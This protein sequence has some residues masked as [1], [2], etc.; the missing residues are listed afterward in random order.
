MEPRSGK[1]LQ[2]VQSQWVV[3][4]ALVLVEVEVAIEPAP[5]V[6]VAV[7]VAAGIAWGSGV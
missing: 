2:P 4:P 6:A 3:A 1:M 5:E 7:A